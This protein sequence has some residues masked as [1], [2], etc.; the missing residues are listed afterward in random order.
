MER[1]YPVKDIKGINR[2]TYEKYKAIPNEK[3]T[4]VGRCGMY[5]YIDMDQAVNIALQTVKKHL[6]HEYE[7]VSN[8][9]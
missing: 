6:G 7:D 5:V 9:S 3:T 4:F 8:S 1:Y 2:E